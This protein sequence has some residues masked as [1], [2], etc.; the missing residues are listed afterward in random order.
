MPRLWQCAIHVRT[1]SAHTV[2]VEDFSHGLCQVG[3]LHGD[4]TNYFTVW[5]ELIV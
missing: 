4:V 1:P 2:D 5:V 3:L